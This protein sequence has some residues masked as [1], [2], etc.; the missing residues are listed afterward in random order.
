MPVKCKD[1]ERQTVYQ[2]MCYRVRLVVFD[3]QIIADRITL[4]GAVRL[5]NRSVY[6]RYA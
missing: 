3:S 5:K 1:K 6:D 4:K 2:K